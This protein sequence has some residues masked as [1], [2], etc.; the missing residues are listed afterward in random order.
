MFVM[1]RLIVS[2]FLVSA[3]FSIQSQTLRFG[4]QFGAAVP[5]GDFAKDDSNPQNA[6]FA[7]TGFDLKFIGERIMDNNLITGV[8]LGYNIFSI[9]EEALKTFVN[10]ISPEKVITE[11]QA[12]Q[13][14][15]L[16]FRIG[17]NWDIAQEKIKVTPVLDAGL[18]IFS[19][20]YYAFQSDGGDTYLRTG[21]TGLGILLTP[22]LDIV[23]MVNDFVGIKIYGNYQFAKYKVDEE[24]KIL[25]ST[26]GVIS[27]STQ[28]YK[29]NSLCF[30]I[31]ANVSL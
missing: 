23:F 11:T 10:P 9:D 25:G 21:N 27:Q 4:M 17:Y 5:L 7:Q 30:G 20:A 22:G 29:Y 8:N 2:L 16:Q 28:T 13:N 14:F 26:T 1:K 18:G 15:N 19:S 3:V 6:G 31:G 12:F 24:F